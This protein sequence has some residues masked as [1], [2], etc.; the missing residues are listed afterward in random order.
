MPDSPPELPTPPLPDELARVLKAS[1]IAL[2]LRP[3]PADRPG[4]ST[5][6]RAV[7][8]GL[9]QARGVTAPHIGRAPDGAPLW[10]A[11]WTGS[12]THS[13]HACAA[14]IAPAATLR[15]LGIDLEDPARMKRKLWPYILSTPELAALESLPE[16]EAHA[17]AAATFSAKEALYKVLAP[18][19]GRVPGFREVELRWSAPA[20][21]TVHACADVP[22]LPAGLDGFACTLGPHVLALAWLPAPYPSMP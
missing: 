21:F 19:G 6:V 5:A 20:R 7:A 15:S 2:A 4:Q 14:A 3:A 12:L 18:L 10:P 9:L 16:P 8:T 13:R 17:R 1:G 22:C 11:G